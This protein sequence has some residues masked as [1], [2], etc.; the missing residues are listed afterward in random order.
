MFEF[1]RNPRIRELRAPD[2]T[3]GR[4]ALLAMTGRAIL[5]LGVPLL[6]GK[7]IGAIHEGADTS[8]VWNLAILLVSVS[9]ATAICQFYMR[10]L[11]IGASRDF[12]CRLRDRLFA[13][14][15]KLSFSWFNR[16]RTGDIMSRLTSDV[17]A[18]RMG[19]GPGVMHLYQTGIMAI[20]AVSLMLWMDWGLTLVSLLPMTVVLLYIRSLMPRMQAASL[21]VQEQTA[22]VSE[23]SQE[24]FSGSRVVKAFA[25][26]D[27]EISRFEREA[28]LYIDDSMRL[29]M[30]RARMR[31]GIE[32]LSALVTVCVLWLGGRD[33]LNGTLNAGEFV[34]FFG[35]YMLLI[36]PMIAI[37][38]TLSLFQR[39]QV[40]LERLEEFLAIEPE[41]ADGPVTD[42][43]L[44]GDWKLSHLTFT[45][46]G[47][48]S[49]SLVDIDIRIPSG[50]SLA[51][52]GPTG[53]GKSTL[54]QMLGRLL[55][56]PA[57]AVF[58]N[59]FD[60]RDLNLGLLRRSISMVPQDTFLFS[61][62]VRANIAFARPDASI[63]EV[64]A[65]AEAAQILDAIEA[66]PKGFDQIVGER[67]VTLS[68]GQKQRIAI[69]RALLHDAPTLILDDC[70]S[71]VDTDT[72][73]RILEHLRRSMTERTTVFVAH[74]LSSI[75]HC[76][77][78]VVI[79]NGRITEQ[80]DHA[81]LITRGGWYANTW[82]RQLVERE[83]EAA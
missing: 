40:A 51:V 29:A 60:V 58:Q 12:E 74:R 22:R 67:G 49:P 38:W 62:T 24:S 44:T 27:Y 75:M 56:P 42:V 50:S 73:E 23:L 80:G 72:E 8:R 18:V 2:V 21:R 15:S 64:R 11:W 81:T 70:L 47:A 63:E 65:A 16:A 14:I 39:A 79:E 37:G 46:D 20:G 77:H 9:A 26:E 3:R 13:H 53:A 76:E 7:T 45:H 41:I 69:A 10:W 66:F 33:V 1:L 30:L 78:I 82:R 28:S 17:E 54:A 36:W 35:Y 5:A 57:E 55:D 25:R 61:D 34:S 59:G 48:R 4:L 68:G 83:L 31:T 71:A 32:A 6:F 19:V 43:K 52:V